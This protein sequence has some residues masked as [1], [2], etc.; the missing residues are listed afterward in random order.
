MLIWLN[1]ISIQLK[2]K[3][4]ISEQ[5]KKLDW[6]KYHLVCFC[7]LES[8]LQRFKLLDHWTLGLVASEQLIVISAV[9]GQ[10]SWPISF[11][12]RLSVCIY[13]LPRWVYGQFQK[14]RKQLHPL[15]HTSF[16]LILHFIFI[17]YTWK[18]WL[19][20]LW[21]ITTRMCCICFL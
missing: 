17:S 6:S 19:R 13:C 4:L 21:R 3:I 9:I 14:H 20:N 5:S 10:L 15:E 7:Y 11:L 8:V 18:K 2:I 12:P 1:V 16:I